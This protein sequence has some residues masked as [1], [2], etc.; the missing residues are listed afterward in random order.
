MG[1]L[2]RPQA[3]VR[4]SGSGWQLCGVRRWQQSLSRDQSRVLSPQAVRPAGHGSRRIRQGSQGEAVRMPS[5]AS[6]EARRFSEVEKEEVSNGG[7]ESSVGDAGFLLQ[8]RQQVSAHAHSQSQA[9]GAGTACSHWRS[10]SMFRQRFFCRPERPRPIALNAMTAAIDRGPSRGARNRG[11][12]T[13]YTGDQWYPAS[14]TN[15]DPSRPC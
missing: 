6:E 1:E 14:T 12:N 13:P 7:H 8:A 10:S 3:D 15:A 2:C 9:L 11:R 4:F 5:S